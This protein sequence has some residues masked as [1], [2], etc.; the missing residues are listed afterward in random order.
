MADLLRELFPTLVPVHGGKDSGMDGAIADGEGEPFPLVTTTAEDVE[1]NLYE[2]LDSFVERKQPPRKVVFATSR[3]LTPQRRLKLMDLARERGFTLVQVIEKRGVAN[4]L[5]SSPRW[6]KQLLDLSGHSS[7]LSVIPRSRRPLLDLK[8]IGRDQDLEWLRQT[9]GDRVLSGEPGSGKTFLLYHL[10]RE[11]WGL[12]LVDSAGDVA[13]ALRE[14]R[15]EVVIVDDA[16]ARPGLLE[17][18]KHLRHQMDMDFSIVATTW[19]GAR[20]QVIEAMGG[21]SE[22]KVRKLELMTRSEILEVYQSVGVDEDPDTMRYLIDQAANKPGLAVTIATLWL[23]GS[24]REVIDG[25]VL[26]RTL[27]AFFQEF[28]GPEATDILAAFSLGGDRGMEVETVREFLGLNRLQVRQIATGLAA[29]GVLSEVDRDVLAVWPRPLRSAL[30]RTVF[31]PPPGQPRYSYQELVEKT[32]NLGKATEALVEAKAVGAE[33]LAEELRQLVLRSGSKRAWN[34][35]AQLSEPDAQWV[36]ENYLGD[37]VDVGRSVLLRAPEGAVWA[38]LQRGVSSTEPIQSARHPM[39]ILLSWVQDPEVDSRELVRRRR[40]VAWAARDFLLSGGDP[41]TGV[42]GI[43]IGLNRELRG[44]SLDPGG[45]SIRWWSGKLPVESLREVA[46]IWDEVK[47]AI[48]ALDAASW[49]HLSSTLLDWH[50]PMRRTESSE[51]EQQIRRSLVERVLSDLV[52]KSEGSPGFQTGLSRIAKRFGIDLEIE[53]DEALELLYPPRE[54][55]EREEYLCEALRGLAAEWAKEL[56]EQVAK[57]IAFYEQE[58]QRIGYNF[59]RNMSEFC[60]ALAN[61]VAA[62]EKW[63]DEFLQ[64]NLREDLVSPFLYRMVGIRRDSWEQRLE[65]YLGVDLLMSSAVSLVLTLPD[66]PPNLLDQ[67]LDKVLN[68][69]MLVEGLCIRKKVPLP[70]LKSLFRLRSWVT[71]FAAAA[72]EWCSDPQGEIREEIQPEWRDA[73]L[74]AKTEDYREAKQVAGFL[75]WLGI[76]LASDADLALDWLRARLKD[77][78]LPSSFMEDS[79]FALGVRALRKEQKE[80]LLDEF[81]PVQ[82]LRSLLPL[83]IGADGELYRRLLANGSLADHHLWPLGGLPNADWEVLAMAALDAHYTPESIAEATLAVPLTVFGSGKEHWERWDQ[84]FAAFEDHP[85]EDLREVARHGRRQ[86][87]G[88]ARGG[89]LIERHLDL[90]GFGVFANG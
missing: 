8:P 32:P 58:S 89:E 69:P 29:G 64:E 57:R 44:D 87:R 66:P 54:A 9:T 67:A 41:G 68:D 85:R 75:Y 45:T 88:S 2:S 65:D 3:A 27:L 15:P 80:Q 76:I 51:E 5:Y 50:P 77:P 35:L 11:G 34:G 48:Q 83:L 6:C 61:S 46:K 90:Y 28:V 22:D 24:W 40:M 78:D 70:T 33:I 20:D 25:N 63:L 18:L 47:G 1:R 73:I 26:S 55:R 31:F 52:P 84:A 13:G 56:P 21:I 71:A 53:Q 42:H 59:I 16:H 7:V 82:I 72:G 49:R 37:L 79:A 38:L 62:P 12:F 17:E 60:G 14:Q 19:E 81:E 86:T 74:R 36:L 10:A 4:L 23:A 30:I 39:D 43:C